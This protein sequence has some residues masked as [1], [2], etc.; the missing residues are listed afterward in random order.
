MRPPRRRRR[1][2]VLLRERR[3]KRL[4]ELDLRLTILFVVIC[5]KKKI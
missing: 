3:L 4:T 5:T 2:A 1:E